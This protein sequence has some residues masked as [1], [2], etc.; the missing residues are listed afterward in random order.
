MPKVI[1]LLSYHIAEDIEKYIFEN[2]LKPGDKIPSERELAHYYN[3]TRVTLRH[4]LQRLIDN[5]VI[6]NI[7]NSG[8]FVSQHKYLRDATS[9]FFPIND[10]FLN[11][12]SYKKEYIDME[13]HLINFIGINLFEE[14]K[15]NFIASTF[16]EKVNDVPIALTFTL[17]RKSTQKKYPYLFDAPKPKNLIQKQKIKVYHANDSEMQI[18]NITSNDSLFLIIE[19][20][21]DENN[22]IAICESICVGTR[23]EIQ[24][25]IN[26]KTD[27]K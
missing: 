12:F 21:S 5:G 16:I 24:L 25:N 18:L 14:D 2:A 11:D 10:Y 22:L 19:F 9:Y 4:G 6:Y 8:Y 7:P 13:N 15:K 17:Q 20:V 26:T 3:V 23:C 1:N 27:S